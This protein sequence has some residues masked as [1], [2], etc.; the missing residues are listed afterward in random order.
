MPIPGAKYRMKQTSKGPVR[1][2]FAPG[3]Q[4][5]EAK[6]MQTGATHTPAEFKADKLK[7]KKKAP[8]PK[9]SRFQMMDEMDS[10]V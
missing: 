2:A 4:V 10:P 8:S 5:E 9:P 3:G 6:N 7:S 1:L